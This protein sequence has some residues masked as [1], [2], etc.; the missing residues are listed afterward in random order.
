MIGA[1]ENAILARLKAASDA[2][3]L[4]YTY[5]TLESYPT[6]WDAYLSDKTIRAP[7]AWVVFGGFHGGQAVSIGNLTAV[8]QYGLVVMA[9]NA[10]NETAQRQGGP[11]AGEPGSYQL[12]EDAIALL[13]GWDPGVVGASALKATALHQVRSQ[14]IVKQRRI[15]MLAVSFDVPMGFYAMLNG[16]LNGGVAGD[17]ATF[18]ANWDVPGHSIPAGTALPADGLADATDIVQLETGS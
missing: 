12:A 15:S 2:D 6:D 14:A 18:H 3:L 16:P 4:G 8:G 17:F 10:R 7:G 13:H 9:E 5:K 1:I 11:V